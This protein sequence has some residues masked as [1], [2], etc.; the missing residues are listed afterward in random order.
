MRVKID[1]VQG[2]HCDETYEMFQGKTGEL[3]SQDRE[4]SRVL[5]DGTAEPV[6]VRTYEVMELKNDI[7]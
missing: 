6:Y 3:I 2:N 5:I 4:L 7:S 1:L